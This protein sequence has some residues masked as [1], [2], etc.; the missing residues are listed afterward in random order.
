M[1]LGFVLPIAIRPLRGAS[2]RKASGYAGGCLRM[3]A[4][5]IVSEVRGIH[6]LLQYY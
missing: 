3:Q 5:R 1:V 6:S 2:N 4:N